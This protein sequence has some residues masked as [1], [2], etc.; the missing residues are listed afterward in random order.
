MKSIGWVGTRGMFLLFALI[1]GIY[2]FQ[3]STANDDVD[4][5]KR[6]DFATEDTTFGTNE[7]IYIR[8]P[9]ETAKLKEGK[10]VLN[11]QVKAGKTKYKGGRKLTI[12]GDKTAVSYSDDIQP[13]FTMGGAWF[14]YGGTAAGACVTCHAG[15]DGIDPEECPPECHLMDLGTRAGILHGADG[16]SVPILGE[17]AVGATDYD[18]E[19]SDLRKRLRNN[20][21]PPGFPFVIDESNRNGADISTTDDGDDLALAG[22][23]FFVKRHPSAEAPEIWE[24]EYGSGTN[25]IGLIGAWVTGANAGLNEENDVPYG[26]DADVTWDDVSPFFNVPNTWY[27]GGLACAS[28]HFSDVEPPSF[29]A[30]NLSSA[31]GL[32]AGAD[33]GEEP[34]LGESTVGSTDF[35][36]SKSGLRK[37]LRNNRMPPEAPFVLD[38]SGR[39]GLMLVHPVT[40]NDVSAVDLIGE[41]VDA[42]CPDN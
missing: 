2:G 24:Y 7:D 36:W 3:V 33:G 10:G 13:L 14:N 4:V 23:N 30:M 27:N 42:G 18:W 17:S 9:H 8:I 1:G 12:K 26:G 15:D 11:V 40:G 16:G 28:C 34:I 20:R 35:N 22:S 31:A 6:Q 37:R 39:D 21:M 38:E 29:H 5:S 32:R 19:K 25:A 41:W